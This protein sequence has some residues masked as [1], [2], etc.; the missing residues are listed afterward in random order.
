LRQ[1]HIFEILGLLST[2]YPEVRKVAKLARVLMNSEMDEYVA[3]EIKVPVVSSLGIKAVIQI[4]DVDHTQ[5][6]AEQ[7]SEIFHKFS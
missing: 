2:L 3:R 7:A 1:S 6:T 5:F 4:G